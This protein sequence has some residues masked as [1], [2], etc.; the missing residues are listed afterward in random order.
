MD[1]EENCTKGIKMN[2][3]QSPSILIK[4]KSMINTTKI[5]AYGNKKNS[6]ASFKGG[7]ITSLITESDKQIINIFGRFYGGVADRLGSKLASLSQESNIFKKNSRFVLENGVQSIKE[8]PAWKLFMESIIFPFTT[9]PRN[10][11]SKVLKTIQTNPKIKNETIKQKA[12]ELYKTPFLRIPRKLNDL[13]SKTNS[14]QGIYEKLTEAINVYATNLTKH[15]KNENKE[16]YFA[17]AKNFAIKSLN[18]ND[19]SKEAKQVREYFQEYLYKFSNKFFDK[20]TGNYN[21]AQERALN[22]IVTGLI[23]A[24]FLANDAYNLSIMCGDTKEMA[25]KEG[26]NRRKQE[27]T[28]IFMTAYVQFIMFSAFTKQV[29]TNKWFAPLISSLTVLLTE[30][31]SRKHIGK[32]IFFLTKEKA[33]AYNLKQKNKNSK[34]Q[35]TQTNKPQTTEKQMYVDTHIG[36]ESKIFKSFGASNKESDSKVKSETKENTTSSKEKKEEPKKALLNFKTVGQLALVALGAGIGISILKNSEL[37]KNSKPV[38]AIKDL[39][40]YIKEKIYNPLAFKDFQISKEEFDKITSSLSNAECA[41]IAQGHEFIKNKYGKEMA[42]G[43]IKIFKSKISPE[44]IPQI[45]EA[46]HNAIIQNGI[47]LT[48]EQYQILTKAIARAIKVNPTLIA[49][50]KFDEIASAAIDLIPKEK[51][52]FDNAAMLKTISA[53]LKDNVKEIPVQVE[54]KLKPFV[55]VITEPFKFMMSIA[56][57]PYNGLRIIVKTLAKPIT[58]KAA[59]AELGTKELKNYERII[60]N[61]VKTIFGEDKVKEGN[62]SQKIFVNAIE[63][64]NKK[65][66]PFRTAEN[67]L[68]KAIASGT[69]AEISA[70]QK[71]YNQAKNDLMVYVKTAVEQSF[72]GVTQSSNSNTELAMLVKLASSLVTSIFLVADNYNMVMIKSDG[73]DKKTAVEKARERVVQRLSA[74]FYQTM[75]IHWF[76]STFCSL[77]HNSLGGMA[78]VASMNTISTEILTRK[79]IGM[80]IGKKSFEELQEI[81]EKNENRKGLLGKYFKFMRLLTGKKPLKDRMPKAKTDSNG[82]KFVPSYKLNKNKNTTNL[83]E[84][85]TK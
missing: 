54:T 2:I 83:I 59:E 53:V 72:N 64:L 46:I 74:L 3:I 55:D 37:T 45:L 36:K 30:T 35:E 34:Q 12:R 44:K 73:E 24:Y 29:N 75:L 78:A 26:K 84:M 42:D 82:N 62:I 22:R 33:K 81:D 21:T 61:A 50:N 10:I 28:R 70:A 5:P 1:F 13:D 14:L 15:V 67:A 57:K 18:N 31:G 48:D 17:R 77:Y 68:N 79:S 71:A 58:Q 9:M 56:K 41:E 65:T 25:T 43:T 66:M 8:K 20:K 38:K 39:A 16:D 63:K 32:P 49:E 47:S 23:P 80:P 7:P 19:P 27:L 85:Y 4:K 6:S 40:K 76:N 11:I 60:N 51:I 52:T 69:Q